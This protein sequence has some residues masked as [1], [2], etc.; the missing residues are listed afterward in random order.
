MNILVQVNEAQRETGI[1]EKMN[2][3]ENQLYFSRSSFESMKHLMLANMDRAIVCLSNFN[4][5]AILGHLNDYYPGMQVIVIAEKPYDKIVVIYHNLKI[6]LIKE[7]SQI[8]NPEWILSEI[9]SQS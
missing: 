8:S 1:K 2:G 9:P 7:P 4:D 5:A 3:A 6:T